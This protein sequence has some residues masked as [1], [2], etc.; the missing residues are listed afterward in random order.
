MRRRMHLI[1]PAGSCLPFLE[2]LGLRS[3]KEIAALVASCVGDDLDVTADAAILMTDEDEEAGG[4]TDDVA[5]AKDLESALADDATAAIV[6]LRGGAWMTRILPRVDFSVLDR[7]RGPVAVFGFSEQTTL[8]NIVA[9]YSQGRG[10]HDMGPAVLAY[11][12]R[13]HASKHLVAQ[14]PDSVTARHWAAER[15]RGEFE[16]FFRRVRLMIEGRWAD[17]ASFECEWLQGSLPERF[18]ARFVGG[19]LTVLS[20]M[21]GSRY[22]RFVE[23]EHRWLVL[24]DF[25][26]KPERMDRF[27]SHLT[28]AGYW[29]RC[30]GLLLG[31]FHVND[32]ELLGPI[33]EMLTFHLPADRELPILHCPTIGHVWPMSPLPLNAPITLRRDEE[34][35]FVGQW[36]PSLLRTV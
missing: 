34:R 12:L 21:I 24:E 9:G 33:R 36:N 28:L 23:P 13:R 3:A 2:A 11:G 1:A 18:E 26:D 7:R 20:T 35:R 6:G 16:R 30:E 4:R 29:D 32:R 22:W 8:V 14:L 5:R 10:V 15:I 17:G 19:N 31:D 25:N 27:L